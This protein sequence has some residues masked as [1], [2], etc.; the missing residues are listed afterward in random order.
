M[1]ETRIGIIS[2]THIPA[3]GD[4]LPE[5]VYNEL[6]KCDLVIHAGDFVS[7][8][9]YEKM[10]SRYKLVAVAGNMD[11]F[12]LKDML[13]DKEVFKV[14]DV[15]IGLI[16]GEGAPS[17]IVDFCLHQF[18]KDNVDIIVCGHSHQSINKRYSGTLFIN[19]GS[20]TDKIFSSCNSMAV[21][22]IDD[23]KEY[24]VKIIKV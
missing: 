7:M 15:T 23:K 8:D 1:A 13:Q 24:N 6:D 11:E 10:K 14:K 21:L 18:E 4:D 16:H 17:G 22:T 12:S 2:D 9:F 20:P 19:P 3:A 5:A